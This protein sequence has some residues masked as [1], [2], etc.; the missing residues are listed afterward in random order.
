VDDETEA[1]FLRRPFVKLSTYSPFWILP[2][3]CSLFLSVAPP[4]QAQAEI[5]PDHFESVN[6]LEGDQTSAEFQGSFS[7]QYKAQCA[8]STLLPGN[9][10]LSLKS[11]GS[12]VSLRKKGSFVNVEPV[13]V[14]KNIVAGES[15]LIFRHAGDTRTLEAIYLEKPKV[16]VF[17]TPSGK[18]LIA[19]SSGVAERVRITAQ[20]LPGK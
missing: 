18:Q 12:V 1:R 10:S 16:M 17:V 9:Y 11:N 8:G 13:E 5:D 2:F 14:V 7:L 19:S 4:S 20:P 15:K 6:L 3:G